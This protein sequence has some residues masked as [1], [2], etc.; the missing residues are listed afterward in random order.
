M[1]DDRVRAVL[2]RLEEETACEGAAG[3]PVERRSLQIEPSS[4]ALLYA[5]C[6]A[7]PG[8]E[9]LEIGGSRGYSTIWLG[10][11]VRGH[12]GHVTSLEVDPVKL[13][14]SRRNIGDA[15]LD[16]WVEVIAGDAFETLE[17]LDGPYD[18]V[19]LDAWKDDY[20]ALFTLA[21]A[22]LDVGAVVV[23]DNVVS[24]PQLAAYSAARQADP[25]A[26][27]VTVPLDNGLEVTTLLTGGLLS[28]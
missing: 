3:L 26:V 23:A 27:S 21:R 22:R 11:A 12:G 20:E 24:H 25:T 18:V 2:R 8:C 10:A 7:R 9:V 4:G 16:E 15:G 5:L 1:L 13:E 28:G 14:A 17:R 6:T 19:F